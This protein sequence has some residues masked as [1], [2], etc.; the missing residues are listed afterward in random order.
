LSLCPSKAYGWTMQLGEAGRVPMSSAGNIEQRRA[1]VRLETAR[2]RI[3]G[4]LTL[5]RDGYRSRVSD[6]LNTAER[7]PFLSL[8][9]VTLEP[10]DD[11]APEHH[12]FLAVSRSQVVFVVELDSSEATEAADQLDPVAPA[13]RVV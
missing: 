13:P 2:H 11:G 3:E 5:P 4:C 12:R 1:R 6:Y 10:F 9:D 7:G 8:T